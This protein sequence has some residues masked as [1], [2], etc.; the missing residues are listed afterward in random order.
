MRLEAAWL[1]ERE[2]RLRS[3]R[4]LYLGWPEPSR[5]Q[6]VISLVLV[7]I[8]GTIVAGIAI[9]TSTVYG[10]FV[11]FLFALSIWQMLCGLRELKS[12]EEFDAE[13]L[14]EIASLRDDR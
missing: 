14:A 10:L 11:S 13:R 8:G 9:A 3:S 6:G 7:G 12:L 1:R 4:L 5:R 2:S